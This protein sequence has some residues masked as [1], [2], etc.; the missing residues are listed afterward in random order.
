MTRS[1]APRR[2]P[3][4]T[5]AGSGVSASGIARM[6]G[7]AG[8]MSNQAAK[9][10]KPAPDLATVSMAVAGTILARMVPNRSTKE[11]RKYLT[12]APWRCP[13]RCH[14]LP[15]CPRLVSAHRDRACGAARRLSSRC[16]GLHRDRDSASRLSRLPAL[17]RDDDRQAC[18][19]ARVTSRLPG[20]QFVPAS[21][22]R[23]MAAASTVSATR[24]SGSRLCTWLLP[25][26]RAMVCASSVSTDR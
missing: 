2:P 4:S 21:G 25:Q 20:I 10:A 16:R 3:A 13:E 5:A 14:R 23:A 26:A 17:G 24:S 8:V 15:P 12:P 22:T 6:S 7:S 18:C 11:I 19:A 9:P 1:P